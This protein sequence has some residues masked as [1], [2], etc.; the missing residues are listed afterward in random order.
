[1][2]LVKVTILFHD[3]FIYSL[4]KRVDKPTEKKWFWHTSPSRLASAPLCSTAGVDMT[5]EFGFDSDGQMGGSW[6]P[7][8]Y[9]RLRVASQQW[10]WL[11]EKQRGLRILVSNLFGCGISMHF[12]LA[13]SFR[14]TMDRY[15]PFRRIPLFLGLQWKHPR[16]VSC[17][18]EKWKGNLYD[19][20][21]PQMIVAQGER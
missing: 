14:Y 10:F 18:F 8:N 13:H 21:L 4:N 6:H 12:R 3:S 17:N 19:T 2:I 1:M 5:S 9:Q 7:N 20:K 11:I 16:C 15:H